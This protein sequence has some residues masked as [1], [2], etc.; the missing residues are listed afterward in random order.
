MQQLAKPT[1]RLFSLL[2]LL[3]LGSSFSCALPGFQQT[4]TPRPAP[5]PEGDLITFAAPF[6]IELRPGSTIT[7]TQIEY[8][9]GNDDVYEFSINGL[10]AY[11]QLGDSLSWRGVIAPGVFGDYR[12]RLQSSFLEPLQ[13]QGEVVLTVFNPAPVEIPPTETPPGDLYVN[14]ISVSY[15][16]PADHRIPGTTLVYEGEQNQVAELS[17]T[18]GYPYFALNDSLLWSGKLRENVY[19]RYNLQISNLDE[20]WLELNGTA[21]IWIVE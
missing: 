12:L 9:Q 6:T 1:S 7:G 10:Q 18:V 16:V 11:R 2:L 5:T 3:L 15:A 21:E 14:D 20:A 4:P 8:I 13:A 17:G 19:I